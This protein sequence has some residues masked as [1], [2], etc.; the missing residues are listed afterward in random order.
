MIEYEKVDNRYLDKL[1]KR[2]NID[3]GTFYKSL[4]TLGGGEC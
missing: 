4:G 2:I 3:P 1:I